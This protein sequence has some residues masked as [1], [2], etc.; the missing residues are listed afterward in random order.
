MF[1]R[2]LIT[3]AAVIACG[4]V[5]GFFYA[6]LGILCA[7]LAGFAAGR[8]LARDTVRTGAGNRLN[9]LSH[10]LRRRGILAMIL[11]RRIRIAP[12]IVVSMVAGAIRI[13]GW[14]FGLGTVI[15]MLPGVL[16]ATIFWGTASH[17]VVESF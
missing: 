13:K 7:A 5:A 17:R 2:P 14:H 1:P 11:V 12:F 15:G 8:Q 6:L 10:A 4:A 9:R 16:A 3:L